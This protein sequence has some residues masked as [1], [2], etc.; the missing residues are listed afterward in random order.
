MHPHFMGNLLLGFTIIRLSIR[1][2]GAAWDV[3]NWI[4]H[5]L[6]RRGFIGLIK[7]RLLRVERRD[8][9]HLM[10][11]CACRGLNNIC[12]STFQF[13]WAALHSLELSLIILLADGWRIEIANDL[14]CTLFHLFL[15]AL[16]CVYFYWVVS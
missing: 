7:G 5:L 11:A 3:N 9:W 10:A 1:L 15:L 8:D 2:T 12:L 13:N 16:C 6:T 4:E 14:D